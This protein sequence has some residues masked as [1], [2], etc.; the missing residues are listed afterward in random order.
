MRNT[1]HEPP[2]RASSG[3]RLVVVDIENVAGGAVQTAE[4]AACAHLS[5]D[6]ACPLRTDDLVVIGTSHIGVVASG[7]GW[8][9]PRIVVRSGV[10]GADLALLE[11]LTTERVAERFESV[12]LVSG[13]GIF[14]G[15]VA[16]LQ[17]RGVNVTVVA[18]A[19]RC[20]KRLRLAASRT[21]FLDAIPASRRPA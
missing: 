21:V 12:V 4:Q 1:R 6:A 16:A 3:R 10:D 19:D 20:A 8:P 5:V 7:I 2:S 18:Y 11:V 17:A 14:T 9:G 15:A 13:D